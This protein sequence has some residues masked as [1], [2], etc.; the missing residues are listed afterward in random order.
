MSERSQRIVAPLVILVVI[1]LAW[2]G[3]VTALHIEQFLLPKPTAILS[4]L[5]LVARGVNLTPI[6]QASWFTLK[7]ALGGLTMGAIAGALV[8]LATARWTATR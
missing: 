8:A 2:E 6:L 4:N 1:L 3:L 5:V 7:E